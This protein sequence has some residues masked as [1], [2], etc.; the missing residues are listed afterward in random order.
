MCVGAEWGR[1]PSS[2]YLPGPR[3]RPVYFGPALSP[4]A[5]PTL[6]ARLPRPYSRQRVRTAASGAAQSMRDARAA[7]ATHSQDMRHARQSVLKGSAMAMLS[8]ADDYPT[9]ALRADALCLLQG[10][11]LAWPSSQR[12]ALNKGWH[13]SAERC[14]YVFTLVAPQQGLP[15]PEGS[16]A[17][18][19]GES[20][21]PGAMGGL[22]GGGMAGESSELRLSANQTC[23]H[24]IHIGH[25]T[26]QYGGKRAIVCTTLAPACLRPCRP[27]CRRGP[28]GAGVWLAARVLPCR[29]RP[30]CRGFA[31]LVCPLLAALPSNGQRLLGP[32]HRA[33]L[34][35]A[36][37]P[38]HHKQQQRQQSG[39][40]GRGWRRLLAGRATPARRRDRVVA[41]R[42][43]GARRGGA[44]LPAAAHLAVGRPV[45]PCVEH[46]H[47]A[48]HA[49]SVHH[50]A[51]HRLC[52]GC[53][54]LLQGVDRTGAAAARRCRKARTGGAI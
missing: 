11:L 44:A 17:A 20:S 47:G 54:L 32:P 24:V 15:P 10:D 23:M 41:R 4:R 31:A 52:G 25:R 27:H 5:D 50:H 40:A 22:A 37:A 19:L 49:A 35:G 7:L 3:Y 45:E 16:D 28:L 46:Q 18:A 21:S 13:I 26:V 2:F 1:F 8:R 14:E 39:G 53:A 36:A 30:R 9:S 29:L 51:V 34:L 6:P 43:A 48:A 33:R 38:P 42:G 12:F